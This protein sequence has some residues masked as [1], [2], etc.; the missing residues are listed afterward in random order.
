MVVNS[1]KNTFN[2]PSGK[3]E[4]SIISH[5]GSGETGLLDNCMLLYRGLKENKS[6]DYHTEM[7]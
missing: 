1:T 3:D 5:V 4:R 7:N 2:V 6:D